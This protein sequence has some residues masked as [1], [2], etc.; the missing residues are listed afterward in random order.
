MIGFKQELA[1]DWSRIQRER[2]SKCPMNHIRLVDSDQ[3]LTELLKEMLIC[4]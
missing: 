4:T 1:E 3:L 2:L